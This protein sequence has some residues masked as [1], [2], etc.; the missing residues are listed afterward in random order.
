MPPSFYKK[1]EDRDLVGTAGFFFPSTAGI[2]DI[3]EDNFIS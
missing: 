1:A 2:L 3:L